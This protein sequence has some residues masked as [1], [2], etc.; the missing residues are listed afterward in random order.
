MFN[1]FTRQSTVPTLSPNFTKLESTVH[2]PTIS[3]SLPL[4]NSTYVDLENPLLIDNLKNL[5]RSKE[6]NLNVVNTTTWIISK[7][8]EKFILSIVPVWKGGDVSFQFNISELYYPHRNNTSQLVGWMQR[9]GVDAKFEKNK[10]EFNSDVYGKI[11]VNID[12]D[13]VFGLLVGERGS[14]AKN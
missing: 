2:I 5:F 8:S 14:F 10:L 6:I 3:S 7:D 11:Y 4:S 9:N 13:N 12:G 1:W